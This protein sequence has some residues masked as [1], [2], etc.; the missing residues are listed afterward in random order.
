MTKLFVTKLPKNVPSDELK[1][2]LQELM[3]D[4]KHIQ[5]LL[6]SESQ[7]HKGHA[8][9]HFATNEA[10]AGALRRV[11]TNG[12]PSLCGSVIT[13]RRAS[14]ASD[15][16][17]V[18]APPLPPPLAHFGHTRCV[19]VSPPSLADQLKGVVAQCDVSPNLTVVA[20]E[21][22]SEADACVLA[23]GS[24][25]VRCLPP[26]LP[27]LLAPHGSAK[28]Q[29]EVSPAKTSEGANDGGEDIVETYENLGFVAL[30][31]SQLL[32]VMGD[33]LEGHGRIAVQDRE[34]HM[35]V[36]NL[37]AYASALDGGR[38]VLK[39]E[40]KQEEGDLAES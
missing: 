5:L 23:N 28:R 39:C 30:T 13:I 8:Y 9:V 16:P 38:L 27:E 4:A 33:F 22:C 10:A 17:D 32:L 20:F 3:P 26:R 24:C 37:P 6:G 2:L 40:K 19:A 12:T 25:A 14:C 34:G 21:S 31:P 7:M 15:V 29:R 35:A 11:H 36:L 18:V 1:E